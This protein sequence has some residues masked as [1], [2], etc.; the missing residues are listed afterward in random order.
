MFI[1]I[2][3]RKQRC[4]LSAITFDCCYIIKNRKINHIKS[5]LGIVQTILVGKGLG[6]KNR[7]IKFRLYNQEEQIAENILNVSL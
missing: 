5:R 3:L 7:N 1:H 6:L 4:I 2:S